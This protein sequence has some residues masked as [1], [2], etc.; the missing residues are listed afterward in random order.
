MAMGEARAGSGSRRARGRLG[1]F[2]VGAVDEGAHSAAPPSSLLVVSKVQ[3]RASFA[4]LCMSNGLAFSSI[5][6]NL[7]F[8]HHQDFVSAEGSDQGPE[9][10]DRST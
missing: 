5:R 9:D 2:H 8:V 1:N 4:M 10:W 6:P 3:E 7:D